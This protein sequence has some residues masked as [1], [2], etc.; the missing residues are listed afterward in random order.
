[1]TKLTV[2]TNAKTTARRKIEVVTGEN[3]F[4]KLKNRF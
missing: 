2:D 3:G 4:P 1:M